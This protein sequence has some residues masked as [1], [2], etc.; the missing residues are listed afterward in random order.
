MRPRTR[1]L[2]ELVVVAT[3]M[4]VAKL[5]VDSNDVNVENCDVRDSELRPYISQR[6]QGEP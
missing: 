5:V 3:D 2:D 4:D 1:L 6:I